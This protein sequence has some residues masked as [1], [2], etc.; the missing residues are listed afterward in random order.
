MVSNLNAPAK[1]LK[2]VVYNGDSKP[3][4]IGRHCNNYCFLLVCLGIEF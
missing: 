1:Q 2:L 3:Y 4:T